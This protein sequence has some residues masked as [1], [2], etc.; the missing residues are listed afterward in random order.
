MPYWAGI[1]HLQVLQDCSYGPYAGPY[2]GVC[3][4]YA[5]VECGWILACSDHALL[6]VECSEKCRQTPAGPVEA[7]ILDAAENH[8]A[9]T[10]GGCLVML[11]CIM[12]CLM[13][14]AGTSVQKVLPCCRAV[15]HPVSFGAVISITLQ[16]GA[17]LLAASMQPGAGKAWT[18]GKKLSCLISVR[19]AAAAVR[20]HMCMQGR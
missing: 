15:L 8:A 14:T 20:L 1:G 16:C 6:P 11:Y 13:G 17:L 3:G 12:Y 4:R 5:T 9:A 19:P 10:R 7:P 18:A 2:F